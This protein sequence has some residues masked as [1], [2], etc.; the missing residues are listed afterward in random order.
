MGGVS[1]E[2][3]MIP[4]NDRNGRSQLRADW[5]AREVWENG[6][7]AFFDNRI[8]EADAQS[9]TNISWEAVANRAANAKKTKYNPAAEELLGTFTPLV[10]S[11]DGVLHREYRAYQI[12]QAGHEMAET[13]FCR[14]ELGQAADAVCSLSCRRPALAR[15][16]AKNLGPWL[17]RW[18]GHLCPP[19]LTL[20]LISLSFSF[21]FLP[22]LFL[23]VSFPSPSLFSLSL[24]LSL[25]LSP[26]ITCFSLNLALLSSSLSS[27]ILFSPFLPPPS[28]SL[29][30][31]FF[32]FC[33]CS[34][35][36]CF[37]SWCPKRSLFSLCCM[38][39]QSVF[40]IKL[41]V[42]I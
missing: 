16:A 4:E 33:L 25:S 40:S 22:F 12:K 41:F 39:H 3:I 27:F 32:R 9:Y 5:M 6:R 10:C 21:L 1:V 34:R 30:L 14:N 20:T 31:V 2:P 28:L 19:A 15:H 36:T 8:M 17:A 11:T 23:S 24:S 18:G 38:F 7:M 42:Y 35:S 26:C 37:I 13:L 29:P